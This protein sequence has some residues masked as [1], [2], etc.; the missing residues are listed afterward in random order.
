M[1]VVVIQK[2]FWASHPPR[3]FKQSQKVCTLFSHCILYPLNPGLEQCGVGTRCGHLT[4]HGGPVRSAA[5]VAGWWASRCST[6]Y[7]FLPCCCI[8][9]LTRKGCGCSCSSQGWLALTSSGAGVCMLWLALQALPMPVPW[10]WGGGGGCSCL[11]K[12]V[13]S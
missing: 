5:R 10:G 6:V 9:F 1:K 12:E 2:G 8:S 3:N 13:S 7:P 4:A 11:A